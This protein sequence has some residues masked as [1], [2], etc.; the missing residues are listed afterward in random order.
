MEGL[1]VDRSHRLC[2]TKRVEKK[3]PGEWGDLARETAVAL[4]PVHQSHHE[5]DL[6]EGHVGQSSKVLTRHD[7][8][9]V[10]VLVHVNSREAHVGKLKE[11]D[12]RETTSG[13]VWV[14]V[15]FD[16]GLELPQFKF[17]QYD[18]CCSGSGSAAH[19]RVDQQFVGRDLLQDSGKSVM[20]CPFEC[21]CDRFPNH[22]FH[23][24]LLHQLAVYRLAVDCVDH[25]RL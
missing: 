22:D 3:L 25:D 8:A 16:E 24:T 21:C 7:F 2:L 1:E 4:E 15:L 20:C 11:L 19:S 23:D 10:P 14:T 6:L 13:N 9:A 12:G 17:V 18:F 5:R